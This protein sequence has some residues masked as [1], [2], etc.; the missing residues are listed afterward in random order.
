MAIFLV[1]PYM[2]HLLHVQGQGQG[3]TDT[4]ILWRSVWQIQL[5]QEPPVP[6]DPQPSKVRI[7][8]LTKRFKFRS[9]HLLIYQRSGQYQSLLFKDVPS[10]G[11]GNH[12][13]QAIQVQKKSWL[14]IFFSQGGLLG[15]FFSK[16]SHVQG[17]PAAVPAP[18]WRGP[19]PHPYHR[20][21]LYLP[22]L[23]V[24]DDDDGDNDYDHSHVECHT[25][26]C[27]CCQLEIA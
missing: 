15:H 10:V 24:G 25:A 14:M 7:I 3:R 17:V 13:P 1:G 5:S 4:A 16:L 8:L 6:P 27:S 2:G 20:H 21:R 12:V 19:H 22:L 11:K 26:Q 9:A 18:G 23:L